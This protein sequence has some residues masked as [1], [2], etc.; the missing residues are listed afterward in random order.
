MPDEE[1]RPL[2][3]SLIEKITAMQ[4]AVSVIGIAVIAALAWF[5]VDRGKVLSDSKDF[6]PNFVTFLIAIG[7][8][9][10]VLLAVL[11]L[12]FSSSEGGN[13][14]MTRIVDI[15]ATITPMQMVASVI[16]ILAVTGIVWV[17]AGGSKEFLT[18]SAQARG[19]ITFS[20]AIVTVAIALILVFYVVFGS[21][22]V[23][24]ER[25]TFGKDILMVFVGILGTI[26]GFY[27]GNA[28]KIDPTKLPG[29]ADTAQ[30]VATKRTTDLEQK[31]FETLL[32]QDIEASITAFTDVFNA[33]P[34]SSNIGNIIVIRKLLDAKKE[35]FAKAASDSERQKILGDIYCDVSNNN[36]AAGMPKAITDAFSK[37]CQTATARPSPTAAQAPAS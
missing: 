23:L 27:Y 17:I 16:G 15:F 7:V 18:D 20:V 34:P 28:D 24:K 35:E 2:L 29:L 11:Y 12:I 32:K 37:G 8:L 3:R 25:F 31:A 1:N 21:S 26:M 36:R 19:L 9:A 5:I 4:I 6:I 10:I 13:S 30:T 33:T 14:I 22:E